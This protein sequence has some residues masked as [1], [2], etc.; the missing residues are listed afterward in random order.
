MDNATM[1]NI[2]LWPL[3]ATLGIAVAGYAFP[4]NKRAATSKP[5]A[6]VSNP[7]EQ[8]MTSSLTAE[9]IGHRVLKLIDSIHNADDISPEHIEK[10]FGMKL[11]VNP[12]DSN[13]YGYDGKLTDAWTYSFGSVTDLKGGK[14]TQL[15]LSFDDQTHSGAD[16]TSICALDLDGYA[17]NLT[18]AGFKASPYYAEHGRLISWD[19]ARGKVAVKINVR[20]ESDTKAT[21]NCVSILTLDIVGA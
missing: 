2:A 10:V 6:S 4:M 18:A 19:F 7:Q 13:D 16:M 14:P 17:K 20:G 3:A 21:H 1:R 15:R 9:E 12:S 11:V 5:Q 8:S